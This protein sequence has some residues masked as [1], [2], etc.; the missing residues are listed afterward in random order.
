MTI[1][2]DAELRQIR[3]MADHTFNVI[4]NVPEYQKDQVKLMMDLLNDMV[5]VAMVKADGKTDELKKRVS[6]RGSN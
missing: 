3:S 5:A 1:H 2:F 6:K 4:L